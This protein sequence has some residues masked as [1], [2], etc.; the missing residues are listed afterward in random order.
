[1]L[2]SYIP[3]T[4]FERQCRDIMPLGPNSGIARFASIRAM[5]GC[6]VFGLYSVDLF[7]ERRI[8]TAP[9][10]GGHGVV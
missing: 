6:L 5:R 4:G 7:A 2:G 9:A 8:Q 10:G 1:M 3:V